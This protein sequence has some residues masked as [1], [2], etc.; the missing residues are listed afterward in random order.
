MLLI[1][2]ILGEPLH[3]SRYEM[4]SGAICG[5]VLAFAIVI[6][7]YGLAYVPIGKAAFITALY[8]LITP[9][10]GLMFH[11][12]C[13]KNVWIAVFIALAG[14]YMLSLWN[15][16]EALTRGDLLL[17]SSAFLYAIQVR[18]VAHYVQDT[19]PLKLTCIMLLTVSIICTAGALLFDRDITTIPRIMDC[20]LPIVYG[21]VLS[22]CAAYS[23]QSIAQKYI[24][25][26]VSALILSTETVFSLIAGF[27]FFHEILAANEYIGCAL[28]A[29]AIIIAQLPASKQN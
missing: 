1:P 23:C 21:G 10:L 9:L 29:S 5:S 8:I 20:W 25:A 18:S 19:D 28:M 4:K 17:F 13:R 22:A 7:Q 3:F 6:Q 15:G 12:P 24:D 26:N 11:K 16:V 27:L 14:M 2:R